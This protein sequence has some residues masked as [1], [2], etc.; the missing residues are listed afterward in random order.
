[1]GAV[2][3][4]ATPDMGSQPTPDTAGQEGN[5]DHCEEKGCY[6]QLGIRPLAWPVARS[7][8]RPRMDLG[9]PV[10]TIVGTMGTSTC[11]APGPRPWCPIAEGA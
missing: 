1:M 5:E 6:I 10:R 8:V 7:V 9:L 11:D 2:D 3:A 4:T